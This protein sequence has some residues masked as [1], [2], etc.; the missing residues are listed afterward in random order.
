VTVLVGVPCSDGVVIGADSIATSSMGQFPLIHL[1]ADPKIK[2]FNNA[3]IVATTGAVG[4]TQRLHHHIEAAING[5]V[6]TNFTARE[7]TANIPYRF[8]PDLQAT[9]APT[10]GQEGLRFGALIAA[11]ARD[12]PF[13]AE[14][15]TTDFQ[16]ELKTGKIFFVSMGSGQMLADPFLAFVC[17]VL[18]REEMP[19]VNS[20]KFGVY[21]VLAHTIKLAPGR[22]GH[23]I[24]LATLRQKDGAWVAEEQDTQEAAQY[25]DELE[26]YIGNFAPQATI[27]EA[28]A[29]PVPVPDQ[30]GK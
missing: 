5:A 8:I 26:K 20:G 24:C 28:Q 13:L 30:D 7:A 4:Y 17:R 14:F 2:I 23:P 6:F 25:I 19:D 18:W 1:E 11:A 12:G 16:P 27:E 10:W 9:K 15:G 21:W 29:E 3:V 22:V